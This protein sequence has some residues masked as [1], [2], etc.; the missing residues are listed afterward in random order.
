MENKTT[1]DQ[2]K[3]L[4]DYIVSTKG[5][6]L[7]KS[8]KVGVFYIEE[9]FKNDLIKKLEELAITKFEIWESFYNNKWTTFL[10]RK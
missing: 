5:Y 3:K 10:R 8:K 4:F 2:L 6:K 1:K 7:Y 9:K